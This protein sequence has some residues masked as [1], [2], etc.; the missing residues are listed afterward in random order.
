MKPFVLT[1]RA[2]QDLNEIW[3][4]IADDNVEAAD[5]VLRALERAIRKLASRRAP[6]I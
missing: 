6:A 1:P 4:Y 5:R 2:E 3:E